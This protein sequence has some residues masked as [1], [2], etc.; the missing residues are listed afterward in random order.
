MS[1]VTESVAIRIATEFLER[2][3][4]SHGN[5]VSALLLTTDYLAAHGFVPS[6]HQ[7]HWVIGI[8]VFPKRQ[9]FSDEMWEWIGPEGQQVALKN[10]YVISIKVNALTGEIM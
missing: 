6:E 4:P 5:I 7:D 9:E 8:Q 2:S 3:R 10:P 1:N